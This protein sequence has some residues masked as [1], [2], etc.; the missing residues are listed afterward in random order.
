MASIVIWS[1]LLSSIYLA[2]AVLLAVYGVNSMLL[3][4]LFLRRRRWNAHA[5][6][7]TA[8]PTVTVQ[9]PLYNE[10]WVARR[11]LEAVAGLDYPRSLLEV[12]VLDDYDAQ[13]ATLKPWQYCGSVYTVAAP[14]KRV[15]LPAGTW[16][17]MQILCQGQ[18][19]LVSLNC[20][21]IVDA[22]LNNPIDKEQEHP[23]LTRTQGFIGL[24]NHGS[25]L[26]YRN[27]RIRPLK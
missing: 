5:P 18:K 16:Q 7:L 9:L 22:D 23:G 14:S 15:T 13:Y 8:L 24:Q 21:P 10:R 2:A 12:Q 20:I 6:S 11:L 3:A 17:K 26:D 1:Y 27:I 4:V 19:V 25:R